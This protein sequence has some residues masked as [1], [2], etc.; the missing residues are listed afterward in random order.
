ML[1]PRSAG[2]RAVLL[3]KEQNLRM[4]L[5]RGGQRSY[6]AHPRSSLAVQNCLN[7]AMESV[8]AIR[9]FCAAS[10]RLHQGL[11]W[12]ATYFLFQAVLILDFGL[13]QA[14]DDTLASIWRSAID[15]SR[16]CL[17]KLGVGNA[18][19][20]RCIS[21]L[22]RIHNHHQAAA[23]S[24]QRQEPLAAMPDSTQDIDNTAIQ[25]GQIDY[26]AHHTYAADPAL[27]FSLDGPPMTNLFD[28]VSGFP[29]TQE[30]QNFDYIPGDFY[31]MDDLDFSMNWQDTQY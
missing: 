2:P 19:A 9:K 7:V 26:T 25:V 11:S 21:V 22:D 27:Q 28:G 16:Q 24:S 6:K 30:Y 18:A 31:N 14:P 4:M 23:S 20:L 8:Q 5:W 3:W 10:E 1:T 12:Y 15:E 17:S 13:L 29:S